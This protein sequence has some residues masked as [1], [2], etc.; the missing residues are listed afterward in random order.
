MKTEQNAELYEAVEALAAIS[1]V[2]QEAVENLILAY[3]H[4]APRIT[5]KELVDTLAGPFDKYR[6]NS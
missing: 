5:G 2:E 3:M 1:G 4:S 6:Q